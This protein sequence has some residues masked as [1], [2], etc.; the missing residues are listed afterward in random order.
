MKLGNSISLFCLTSNRVDLY[1]RLTSNQ[2]FTVFN[3]VYFSEEVKRQKTGF[4][5]ATKS[6]YFNKF[7]DQS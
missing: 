5:K 3:F 1:L 2:A 6:K 4:K 7:V